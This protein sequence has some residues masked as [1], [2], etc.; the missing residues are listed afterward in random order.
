MYINPRCTP[1]A[2]TTI[3]N[4]LEELA[5]LVEEK[6]RRTG[7]TKAFEGIRDNVIELR[8]VT[9]ILKMEY[10]KMHQLKS[11][12]LGEH[13]YWCRR[14]QN[15][16]KCF[17]EKE[18]TGQTDVHTSKCIEL[19]TEAIDMAENYK[20]Y[21][22]GHSYMKSGKSAFTDEQQIHEGYS[23]LLE[24]ICAME[25]KIDAAANIVQQGTVTKCL[26]EPFL[27]QFMR[28]VRGYEGST[29]S[30]LSCLTNVDYDGRESWSKE[31]QSVVEEW[32]NLISKITS[33]KTS[34]S[35]Q[36]GRV[37]HVCFK[38]NPNQTSLSFARNKGAAV[39]EKLLS[40]CDPDVE[41]EFKKTQ[42]PPFIPAEIKWPRLRPLSEGGSAAVNASSQEKK[43]TFEFSHTARNDGD[44][45]G[46]D[47]SGDYHLDSEDEDLYESD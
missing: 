28:I 44:G 14:L 41:V 8:K 3:I 29:L 16:A 21:P 12:C 32:E 10:E 45:D 26:V 15:D 13:L 11:N 6:L 39:W 20:N 42:E 7:Q 27:I 5:N 40:C 47:N 30:Q 2:V 34:T 19:I 9:A 22:N 33:V 17:L 1:T 23:K 31:K 35:L 25:I 43:Y 18:G 46:D 37:V 36:P 38:N 4:V 24:V